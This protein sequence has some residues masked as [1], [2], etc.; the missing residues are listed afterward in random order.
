[1]DAKKIVLLGL[2]IGSLIGGYIPMLWGAGALSI[3]SLIGNTLGGIVGIYIA[4]QVSQN[5]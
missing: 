4:F 3:A 5:F 2:T 1:M